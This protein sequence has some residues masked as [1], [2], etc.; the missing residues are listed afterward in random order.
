[1]E[2]LQFSTLLS[3]LSRQWNVL[4]DDGEWRE[5]ALESRRLSLEVCRIIIFVIIVIIIIVL[6]CLYRFSEI[7]MLLFGAHPSTHHFPFK[8][9]FQVEMRIISASFVLTF[10]ALGWIAVLLFFVDESLGWARK[11]VRLVLFLSVFS[12]YCLNNVLILCFW[13]RFWFHLTTVA[14][15]TAQ[16]SQSSYGKM[17]NFESLERDMLYFR[18]SILQSNCVLKL[19]PFV[20]VLHLTTEGARDYLRS[21]ILHGLEISSEIS[22]SLCL[23]GK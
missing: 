1:M 16:N 18:S 21:A 6:R 7:A 15:F 12:R 11:F 3:N 4:Q 13:R 14:T 9:I 22:L 17:V 23:L 20:Y 8:F 19:F 10:L 2:N 5:I